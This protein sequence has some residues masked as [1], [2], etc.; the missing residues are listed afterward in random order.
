L[1]KG[2]KKHTPA[3]NIPVSKADVERAKKQA[4]DDAVRL[5]MVIFPSVLLDK[6]GYDKDRLSRCWKHIEERSS[7][8]A[9]GRASVNDWQKILRDEYGITLWL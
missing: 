3:R 5:A 4:A 2:K 6:E 7:A 8:I 9:E 1:S